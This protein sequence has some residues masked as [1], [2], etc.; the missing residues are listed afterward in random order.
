MAK[1]GRKRARAGMDISRSGP[2][3]D[4]QGRGRKKSIVYYLHGPTVGLDSVVQHAHMRSALQDANRLCKVY[5][6]QA[7]QGKIK[8]RMEVR[9]GG[10]TSQHVIWDSSRIP[11][12]EQAP[13]GNSIPTL[14][15]ST[16][17]GLKCAE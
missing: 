10:Q 6:D 15:E 4:R 17:P 13:T 1:V 7:M 16:W 8:I 2:L 14:E 12:A 11:V 3:K 9:C 5:P